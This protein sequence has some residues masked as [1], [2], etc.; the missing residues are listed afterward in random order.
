MPAAA[1]NPPNNQSTDELAAALR[2]VETALERIK[3]FSEAERE[4]LAADIQSLRDM[5]EKL[6]DGRIE[7]AIFGEI[8][9][10]KSA[11][12]NALVGRSATEVNIRGGWTKDVWQVAWEGVGYCVPGFEG[13]SLV[14]LDTPGLNE[15][16]G[17]QRTAM[18]RDVARRADLVLFVTDSDLNET[19]YTALVEL[20]ASHKPLILVLNKSDLYTP[21]ELK[22]LLDLFRN[23]RLAGL[24]D[25]RNIVTTKADPR[26]IEY[27]IEHADGTTHSEWRKPPVDVDLLR[28]R[29]VEV[30][31]HD[32]KEL[33]ALN[34]S[35]FAADRSD[36]MA[37]LRIK[38]RSE[39]AS[40]LIWT[41]AGL[42]ALAVGLNPHAALDVLGGSA[43][44]A[45]MVIMLG[46]IYGVEITKTGA[47][48]LVAS[49][50]KAAGWVVAGEIVV[51]WAA[52]FAKGFTLGTSTV[53]TALPQ[54]AAAGYGSYIVGQAARYYF[55]HG[56]SWGDQ[57]AKH[58]V[59]RILDNTDKQSVIDSLKD[60][61]RE[62]LSKNQYS[63]K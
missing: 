15:V 50:L 48:E 35:M 29:I 20:A 40:Q 52:S 63:G 62:K 37:A 43:V 18:A 46:R 26:Q 3:G 25:P 51:S 5:A 41:Y 12:I 14:L 30:L 53:L 34:A 13:S 9:T 47:I 57:G 39:K 10:G 44:D 27:V 33:V 38:L 36:R 23:T 58:V 8:S 55:E 49:I 54:G 45:T 6:R 60:K 42:K 56:A 4:A 21:D 11:L 28:Q 2:S 17:A 22:A 32:G 24:V 16:D 31:E 1:N 19:E 59:K 7:I 61:I